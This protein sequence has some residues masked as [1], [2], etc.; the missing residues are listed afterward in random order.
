MGTA[1]LSRTTHYDM[2][3]VAV[4]V[5]RPP[6]WRWRSFWD[7]CWKAKVVLIGLL[8]ALIFEKLRLWVGP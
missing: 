1:D 6:P 5:L 2:Q 8:A 7:I 3:R 4:P